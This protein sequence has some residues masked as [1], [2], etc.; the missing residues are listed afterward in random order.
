MS[1]DKFKISSQKFQESL[2][3]L[4]HNP[5]IISQLN[6]L[7]HSGTKASLEAIKKFIANEKGEG[8]RGYA[9]C[10]LEECEYFYYSPNSPQEETDFDLA[11]M[12]IEKEERIICLDSK[13]EAAEFE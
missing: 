13:A 7:A 1:D 12:I 6:D 2:K 11:K 4:E 10:A 5:E 9:Q 3:I 8:L